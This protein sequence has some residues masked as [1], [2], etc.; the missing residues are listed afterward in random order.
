MKTETD[1]DGCVNKVNKY[2]I[3]AASAQEKKQSFQRDSSAHHSSVNTKKWTNFLTNLRM[4]YTKVR[5]SK[6]KRKLWLYYTNV[7]LERQC[8]CTINSII[9][10]CGSLIMGY[11][12]SHQD[13]K[14]DKAAVPT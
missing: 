7:F 14:E 5:A 11:Y 12:K 3:N 8:D 2:K 6:R 10:S 13:L 9:A 1:S 4:K